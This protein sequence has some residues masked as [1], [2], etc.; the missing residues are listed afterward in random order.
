MR[1]QSLSVK[2]ILY[3]AIST[4]LILILLSGFVVA[5]KNTRKIGFADSEPWFIYKDSGE[6]EHYVK[7][8][9]MGKAY[10]IDF[11]YLYDITNIIS[12]NINNCVD[13]LVFKIGNV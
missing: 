2:T 4:L 11:S 10:T 7:L 12:D 8:R 13:E 9:F 6:N 5:E 1:R 3:S